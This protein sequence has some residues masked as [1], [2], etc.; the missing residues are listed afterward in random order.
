MEYKFYQNYLEKA[1]EK[2]T[3]CLV[4]CFLLGLGVF[5]RALLVKLLLR[6]CAI[7]FACRSQKGILRLR[8]RALFARCGKNCSASCH[9]SRNF[10]QSLSAIGTKPYNYLLLTT[11]FASY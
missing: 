10:W 8:R 4:A 1:I 5:A 3:S 2:V 6:L 9:C 7:A 11:L